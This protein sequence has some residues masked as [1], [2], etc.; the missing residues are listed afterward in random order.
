MFL[1]KRKKHDIFVFSVFDIDSIVIEDLEKIK[2]FSEFN[3]NFL[4]IDKHFEFVERPEYFVKKEKP[5]E[6]RLKRVESIENKDQKIYL[7]VFFFRI[8]N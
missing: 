7:C 2:P 6:V 3:D 4:S 5:S 1:D 8:W